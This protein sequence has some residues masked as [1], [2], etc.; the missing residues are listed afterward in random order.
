MSLSEKRANSFKMSF[1]S[2][3]INLITNCLGDPIPLEKISNHLPQETFEFLNKLGRIDTIADRLHIRKRNKF[4][5][6][7]S[8]VFTKILTANFEILKFLTE[9]IQC[10]EL[11]YMIW[12][13][14]HF[15]ILCPGSGEQEFSER[16]LRFQSG[17]K[18]S[19][20]NKTFKIKDSKSE[21]ALL[22]EF[23]NMNS[24]NLL[25]E[26]FFSHSQLFGYASSGL[27]PHSLISILVHLQKFD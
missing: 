25:N 17:S 6:W 19:S 11:P 23:S 10:I 12:I 1:N 18:A 9:L 5:P 3:E 13:D 16:V 20:I 24:L 8:V 4:R 21:N 27:R 22:S 7:D 2:E 15:C 14:F 26:V